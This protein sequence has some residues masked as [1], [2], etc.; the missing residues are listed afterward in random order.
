MVEIEGFGQQALMACHDVGQIAQGLRGVALGSN[1]DV[2]SAALVESLLAPAL[3]SRR[4]I[5]CRVSMSRR[6]GSG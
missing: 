5:S 6:S 2:D 4:I 1:V 3:R